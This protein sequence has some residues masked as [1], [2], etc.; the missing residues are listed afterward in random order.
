MKKYLVLYNPLSRKGHGKEAAEKVEAYLRNPE[1]TYEDITEIEDPMAYICAVPQDVTVIF[2]GGDGTLNKVVNAMKKSGITRDVYYFPAGSG[3]DFMNDIERNRDCGP[4]PINAYIKYLPEV[5]VNGQTYKFING[6]GF[7]LDG[8]CC[9][10]N[11]R[12]KS[13]GKRRSYVMVAFLGLM[14]KFKP[15]NAK[16]T[17][18]GDTREFDHV[19]MVPTMFGR[20][21]GGGV[22][23]TPDQDRHNPEHAV[24]CAAVFSKS[25]IAAL[26]A[27]LS[28]CKGKG[29]KLPKHLYY[30]VGH[31]VHVEFDRPTA[32]QIDGETV[33]NVLTYDV[34]TDRES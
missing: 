15:V 20:F 33:V 12:L 1:V 34:S 14:G 25:K 9:E 28:V 17:V 11:D 16:I 3:N 26:I 31:E 2:T 24:T 21:Y 19:Y 7:G 29:P 8:Y 6:V 32:L 22:K 27:F 18:D 23:I 4:F 10:E 5:R 30:W 13:I